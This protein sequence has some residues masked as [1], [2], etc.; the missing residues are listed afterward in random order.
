M[1]RVVSAPVPADVIRPPLPGSEGHSPAGQFA[2][3]DVHLP[4]TGA[5]RIRLASPGTLACLLSF[6]AQ[7]S[8]VY[9]P[10]VV[11]GE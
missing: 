2:P 1:R 7:A 10:C 8:H 3:A 5:E 11:W 9:A 4:L 6:I